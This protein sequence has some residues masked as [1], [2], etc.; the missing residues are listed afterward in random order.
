MILDDYFPMMQIYYLRVVRSPNLTTIKCRVRGPDTT[1]RLF[2]YDEQIY[3]LLRKG[4]GCYYYAMKKIIIVSLLVLIAC[5]GQPTPKDTVFD[6]IDAVLSS[7]SLRVTKDLDVDAYVKMQMMSMSPEDSVSVLKDYRVKTIQSLLGDG[8]VRQRWS[9]LQIIVNKETINDGK[10]DV[11]VTFG[12][13]ASGHYVYTQMQL[14]KQ[15]DKT[16][17]ITYF[18]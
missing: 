15:A 12:D 5:S 10:A 8:D 17:K 7:D 16:W 13:K 11:E 9:H 3:F 14:E 2:P 18:K 4:R 6:F 1:E